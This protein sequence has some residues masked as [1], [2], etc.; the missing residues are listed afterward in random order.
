MVSVCMATYNGEKYI[1][2]Q[3]DS[4]LSEI[5]END[6][7]VISDDNSTDCTVEII[8]SYNDDR[9]KLYHSNARNFKKNF[10][11]AL[12]KAK[13]DIII[14]SDQDDVWIKGKYEKCIDELKKYDLVVT[15]S[16][17]VDENLNTIY[18]SFFSYYKSGPGILKNLYDNTYF[19]AC[20]AFKRKVLDKAL[21]FPKSQEIGHDVWIGMVGE[22]V[23]KVHFIN[24]SYLYYR[25]HG[26]SLTNLTPKLKNR[27]QRPLLTKIMGRVIMAKEVFSFYIKY[28]TNKICKKN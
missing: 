2:E 4:I 20:M 7:I 15:D 3:I 10:E 1:K 6:E 11:N 23:G 19:G 26:K 24:K 13:G 14:L 5:K 27:S 22:I 8:K 9:I 28:N 16:T 18:P 17:V 21:P 12:N 25:R